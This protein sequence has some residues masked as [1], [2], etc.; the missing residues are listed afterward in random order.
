LIVIGLLVLSLVV[1]VAVLL[2]VSNWICCIVVGFWR[3]SSVVFWSCSTVGFVVVLLLGRNWSRICSC[4][5]VVCSY[6]D[7]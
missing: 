2:L 6:L 3:Y 7:F 5:F 4:S 1:G